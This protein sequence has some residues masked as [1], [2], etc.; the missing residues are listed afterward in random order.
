[1]RACDDGPSH[2]HHHTSDYD[3]EK[4]TLALAHV[5]ELPELREKERVHAEVVAGGNWSV[6]VLGTH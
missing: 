5:M 4:M 1:V 6:V 3:E 2:N